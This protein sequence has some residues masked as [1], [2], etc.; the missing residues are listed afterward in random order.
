M[1]PTSI[2]LH[3]I[4][5]VLFVAAC[6]VGCNGNEQ[7]FVVVR[8]D[9][10]ISKPSAYPLAI[11][12]EKVGK[13]P[14]DAKSGAGY[15]YDDVL[16]YRVWFHPERGAEPLNGTE[17]Y[18]VAFAQY[19]RAAEISKSKKGAEDPLVLV[20][21]TEWIDEPEPGH[22]VPE[23]GNRITEWQVKW[24]NGGRRTP[25]SIAEFMKHPKPADKS[26]ANSEDDEEQ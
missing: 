4:L 6:L 9:R 2:L 12:N 22:Y 13:Y 20:R 16:E 21:Q 14:P 11:D 3:K 23:N 17:D 8:A 10:S 19:E 25:V 18:Y 24:L 7:H 15:F 1:S 26:E 5:S